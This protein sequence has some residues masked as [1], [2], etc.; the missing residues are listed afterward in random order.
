MLKHKSA[1]NGKGANMTERERRV[2]AEDYPKDFLSD[3]EWD[4]IESVATW[5]CISDKQPKKIPPKK[6]KEVK[7][8]AQYTDKDKCEYYKQRAADTSLSDKQRAYAQKRL[9]SLCGVKASATTKPPK[10]AHTP[11][12]R[13]AY[14][15]GAA[16][17]MG[18]QGKQ[19]RCKA[20]NTE[21]FKAGVKA[22][23][24]SPNR[25]AR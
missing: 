9:N 13:A 23:R 25:F 24:K 22:A 2:L 5:G 3:D 20:E 11:S 21:S 16:W 17:A 6:A 19:I 4:F 12:E 1:G 8:M 15:A 14:G 7:K 10:Q 18:K